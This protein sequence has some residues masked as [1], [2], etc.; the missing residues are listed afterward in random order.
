MKFSKF[1]SFVVSPLL[2]TPLFLSACG[3]SGV[4][5]DPLCAPLGMKKAA[6]MQMRESDFTI[7]N[8]KDRHSFAIDLLP[9]LAHTDPDL[10]HRLA[11]EGLKLF[12][13]EGSLDD[14]TIEIIKERLLKTLTSKPS[15]RDGFEKPYAAKA[16]SEIV[17]VDRLHPR[18]SSAERSAL[19]S[20]ASNYLKTIEDYRSFN[21]AEGWRNG[22]V[23]GS[24]L[25][26]QLSLNRNLT[27]EHHR[28]MLEAISAQ[29]V[30]SNNHFYI[31]NEP[32]ELAWPIIFIAAQQTLT[33]PEWEAW[34][35]DLA[36]PAPLGNWKIVFASEEGLAKLHNTKA[37]AS[38]VY[39]TVSDAQDVEMTVLKQPSFNLLKAL[40]R[41]F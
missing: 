24:E 19:V 20:A 32:Q 9:C 30:P 31:H 37:F 1:I 35:E 6:L 23:Q 3:S 36:D 40:P 22:V 13:R 7:G 27:R 25:L 33:Q 39:T 18:Y 26:L 15:N 16:L 38:A 29:V 28:E 11:Y 12:L 41:N 2:A 8:T 34:F 21:A 5:A 4:E 10:R 14:E 17:R